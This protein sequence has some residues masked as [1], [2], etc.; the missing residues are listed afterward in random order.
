MHN[1][2]SC[3]GVIALQTVVVGNNHINADS[4]EFGNFR[5]AGHAAVDGDDQIRLHG[6]Q[7]VEVFGIEAV[8]FGETVR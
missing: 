7:T 6:N 5:T 2:H 1:C 8:A 4:F 3:V